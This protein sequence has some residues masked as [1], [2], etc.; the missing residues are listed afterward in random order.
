MPNPNPAYHNPKHF[1]IPNPLAIQ[2]PPEGL[3]LDAIIIL[4]GT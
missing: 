3:A 2:T 1:P 4:E